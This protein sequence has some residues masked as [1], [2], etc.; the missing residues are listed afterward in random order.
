MQ[1]G[2][3]VAVNINGIWQLGS[4]A[5][6][7]TAPMGV[8]VLFIKDGE[9]TTYNKGE[10]ELHKVRDS[11]LESLVAQYTGIQTPSQVQA[12]KAAA[13]AQFGNDAYGS[14]ADDGL[15]E[16]YEDE[17]E[18]DEEDEGEDNEL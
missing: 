5:K 7:N 18:E 10:V 4:V 16:E 6:V 15:E 17:E 3:V 13:A 8:D 9:T 2:R 14:L 11:Q 12:A 1:A